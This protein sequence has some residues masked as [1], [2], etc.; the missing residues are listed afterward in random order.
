[1]RV[2]INGTTLRKIGRFHVAKSK[3]NRV[4]YLG[5]VLCSRDTLWA[6]G[7]KNTYQRKMTLYTECYLKDIFRNILNYYIYKNFILLNFIL[8]LAC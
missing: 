8:F 3:R 1:M 6:K 5:Y 7:P 4:A 2:K